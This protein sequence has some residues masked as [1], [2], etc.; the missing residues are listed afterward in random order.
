MAKFFKSEIDNT[1]L[2]ALRHS[3]D[4]ENFEDIAD[5][6]EYLKSYYEEATIT[7][8]EVC[9]KWSS[10]RGFAVPVLSHHRTSDV[11]YGGSN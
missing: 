10:R 4:D 1:N 2:F 9:E 6:L 3:T 7:H 8:D 5:I 11:A